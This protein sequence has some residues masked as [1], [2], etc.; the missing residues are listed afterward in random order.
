MMEVNMSNLNKI[1]Q[2]RDFVRMVGLVIVN[3]GIS[4]L[5]RTIILLFEGS[6]HH[7]LLLRNGMLIRSLL[8]GLAVI[9]ANRV[10]E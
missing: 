2:I 10:C 1:K 7:T 8:G 5:K 4:Y 3:K 9:T 6:D